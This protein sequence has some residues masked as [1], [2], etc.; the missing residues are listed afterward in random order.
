MT[1]GIIA[2]G[3]LLPDPGS[4]I[5]VATAEVIQDLV[6]PFPVEYARSSKKCDGS[7]TLVPSQAGA[8]VPLAAS[9]SFGSR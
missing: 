1:V 3:S 5:E 6:T 2:Y 9:S 4:E 8:P 7:P